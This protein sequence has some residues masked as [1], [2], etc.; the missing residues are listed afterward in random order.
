MVRNLVAAAPAYWL[1][2]VIRGRM[3]DGAETFGSMLTMLDRAVSANGAG[4]QELLIARAMAQVYT[5]GFRS[6]MGRYGEAIT[7]L[8][9]G[10]AF[11]SNATTGRAV[12]LSLNMLAAALSMEGR[13][14]EAR[15]R[16]FESLGEFERVHDVWGMAFSLNDLGM[17]SH[18]NPGYD[19]A[20]SYCERS[21]MLFRQV[22]DKRGM[23]LASHNLGVIAM[24][25]GEFRRAMR[26][27]Q[28]TL[29]LREESEDRYGVTASLVQI[30]I[31]SRLMNRETA[32][33]EHLVKALDVAWQSAIVPGLLHALVELA[34]LDGQD[35]DRDHAETLFT[36]IFCHPAL[37]VEV[38]NQVEEQ[39]RSL[40]L[41]PSDSL[42]SPDMDSWAVRTVENAARSLVGSTSD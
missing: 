5:G 7:L 42:C 16:L 34:T 9:E 18:L 39:M 20:Q 38:Q 30:G 11:L 29:A 21:R 36:A 12:G 8:E 19:E 35:D 32:A 22:G 13:F 3:R 14:D 17:I 10:S 28:E 2:F 1:F 40:G 25:R 6:G 23:A 26:L 31:V 4:N 24:N 41:D 33:R 37:H 15:D 27:H